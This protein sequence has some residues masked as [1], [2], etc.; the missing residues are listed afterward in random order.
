MH[1]RRRVLYLKIKKKYLKIKLHS[2]S[3]Y[4]KF[5]HLLFILSLMLYAIIILDLPYREKQ[6]IP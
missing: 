4:A 1:R 5:S 6:S 2:I 3:G